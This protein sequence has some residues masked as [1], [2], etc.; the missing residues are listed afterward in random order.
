MCEFPWSAAN[1]Y[2][3]QGTLCDDE[4]R[5]RYYKLWRKKGYLEGKSYNEPVPIMRYVIPGQI[6]DEWLEKSPKSMT[7]YLYHKIDYIDDKT[8]YGIKDYWVS[9]EMLVDVLS[10]SGRWKKRPGA[11]CEDVAVALYSYL[12]AKKLTARLLLCHKFDPKVGPDNPPTINHAAVMY[13][14]GAKALYLDATAP[15]GKLR[16]NYGVYKLG[17]RVGNIVPVLSFNKAGLIWEHK[18]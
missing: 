14:K 16:R 17:E 7:T 15:R 10:R 1:S 11:D 18:V 12:E 4:K 13:Y 2:D 8:Q 6:P 3:W 9:P 5:E